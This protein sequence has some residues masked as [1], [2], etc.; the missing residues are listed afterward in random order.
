MIVLF[1][2]VNLLYQI[3]P[4]KK[5]HFLLVELKTCLSEQ[6]PDFWN[7]QPMEFQLVGSDLMRDQ[8]MEINQEHR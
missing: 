7:T 2:F 3:I 1:P 5:T 8:Y 6:Q 4:K